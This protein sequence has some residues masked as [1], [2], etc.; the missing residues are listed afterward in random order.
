MRSP[1]SQLDAASTPDSSLGRELW[2][3]QCAQC[4]VRA[5]RQEVDGDVM[6]EQKAN[7]H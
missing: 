3:L 5:V 4:M 1:R 2:L 7:M 6:K